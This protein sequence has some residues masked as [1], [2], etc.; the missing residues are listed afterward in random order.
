MTKISENVTSSVALPVRVREW[1]RENGYRV[2][3][4]NKIYFR[5]ERR[6]LFLRWHSYSYGATLCF[7]N[8]T[9]ARSSKSWLIQTYGQVFKEAAE[10]CAKALSNRF[11]VKIHVVLET[12]YVMVPFEY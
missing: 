11:G 1:L 9:G 4:L 8:N 7:E 2:D 12:E 5:H 10:E 6:F 3:S